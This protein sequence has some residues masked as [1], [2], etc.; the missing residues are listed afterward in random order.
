MVKG[1]RS[2]D[3]PKSFAAFR[4]TE[5]KLSDYSQVLLQD[6]NP[7]TTKWVDNFDGTLKEPATLPARL[8]NI[9]INGATGIAVGLSTD[10]PP[11]NI[12]EIAHACITLLKDPEISTEALHEIVRGPDYPT[13]AEITNS[14][15]EL[16][17]I[18]KTGHGVIRQRATYITDGEMLIFNELPFQSSSSKIIKQIADLIQAKKINQ[19]RQLRDESDEENPVKVVL[20]MR[21]NR[22]ANDAFLNLLFSST[23]L[24]KNQGESNVYQ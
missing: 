22:C 14:T 21:S 16:L 6:L 19:I 23:D 9:I 24:E 20:I 1:L 7:A 2:A 5:A 10:I 17:N 12:N 4:Y 18:Y 15:E 3:D 13:G 8:P 11:H